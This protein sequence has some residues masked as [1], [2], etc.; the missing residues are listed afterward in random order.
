MPLGVLLLFRCQQGGISRSREGQHLTSTFSGPLQDPTTSRPLGGE[1]SGRRRF[2]QAVIGLSI[3]VVVL[4][5]FAWQQGGDG[6]GDGPLNAIAA[7]AERTQREPSGRAMIRSLVSPPERS[8]SFTIT[9]Q[10]VYDDEADRTRA[11]LTMPHPKSDGSVEMRVVTD[12]TA[13]YMRS[14]MFGSLPGGHKWMGLDLSSF[15]PGLDTPLP[16]NV[17]AK[18]ELELLEEVTGD[19]QKLGKENVRGVPTMHYRGTIDASENAERLRED[20]ASLAEGGSPPQIEAWIDAEGLVRRMRFVQSQPEEGGKGSL[21][22]DLRMDF[23]DF[24]FVPEIDVPE[25][26][27]VF[28]ATALAQE[29]AGLPS[30]D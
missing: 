21:T 3:L 28:D 13:M 29:E 18:G 6:D 1:P 7:A 19:V 9:G 12:G 10:M 23:F 24:G 14:S 5:V 30:D 25:S 15:G 4:A 17:D 2:W 27:E 11:V 20:L 26:S 22:I 16:A 8:K